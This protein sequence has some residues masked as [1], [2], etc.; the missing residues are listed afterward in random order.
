MY[1]KLCGLVHSIL[2]TTPV[3]VTGWFTSY[4]APNEWWAR[5]G[6]PSI[7]SATTTATK[8]QCVWALGTS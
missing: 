3:I 2:V 5:A 7:A 6:D 4:S 8:R 1:R